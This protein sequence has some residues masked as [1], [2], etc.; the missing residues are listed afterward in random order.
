MENKIRRHESQFKE[1]NENIRYAVQRIDL[2]TVSLAGALIYY[3]LSND[4]ENDLSALL[5][6]VLAVFLNFVSQ[7]TGYYANVYE[8]RYYV[9]MIRKDENDERFNEQLLNESN[10]WSRW[11]NKATTVLNIGSSLTLF[12]GLILVVICSV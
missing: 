6:L 9:Q 8:S 12:T 10:C 4:C 2:L 5:F 1:A 7:W 11:N 3:V